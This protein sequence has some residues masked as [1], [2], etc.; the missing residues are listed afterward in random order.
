MGLQH[1]QLHTH[2]GGGLYRLLDPAILIKHP[3]TGAWVAGVT[4]ENVDVHSERFGQ[5]YA[6]TEE[7]WLERFRVFTGSVFSQG[8]PDA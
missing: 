8:A 6:C 7:R 1:G 3:D 5:V 2:A 4:Y